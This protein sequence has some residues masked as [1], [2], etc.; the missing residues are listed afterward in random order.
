MSDKTY[1]VHFTNYSNKTLK[2]SY[3]QQISNIQSY[4]VLVTYPVFCVHCFTRLEV[5]ATSQHT[6]L[7]SVTV[8]PQSK[9]VELLLLF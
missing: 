9:V 5:A 2:Y 1:P 3:G 4:L 8:C 6:V 7:H